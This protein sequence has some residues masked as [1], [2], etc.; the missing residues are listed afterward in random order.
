MK[1]VGA[2][3]AGVPGQAA[4]GLELDESAVISFE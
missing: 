2:A 1:G 4:V 3:E